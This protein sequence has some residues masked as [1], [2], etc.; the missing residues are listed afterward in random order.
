MKKVLL[1]GSSFNVMPLMKVL[2]NTN[3]EIVV[4]GAYKNDP[5][6]QYSDDSIY[7]DYSIKE[8]LLNVV[9]NNH[10]DA[11]IPTCNDY[12][13]IS[14]SW[15]ASQIGFSGF[16]P[17]EITK[18]IHEKDD[19]RKFCNLNNIKS[20]QMFSDESLIT[21]NNF[22]LIIKPIDSFSGK[23]ISIAQT[24]KELDTAIEKAKRAS[25]T[26]NIIIEEFKQGTLHA[27]TVFIE[28]GNAKL[29]FVTDEFCS[30][31]PY[32]VNSTCMSFLPEDM[33][34]NVFQEIE[35]IIRLLNL[36]S[37][38]MHVQ[39]LVDGH[40]FWIIECTRRAPGDL[41]GKL[42]K[43]TTG[44]DYDELYVNN[45]LGKHGVPKNEYTIQKIMSKHTLTTNLE[46]V[47]ESITFNIPCKNTFIPL[48]NSCDVIKSAPYDRAGIVFSEYTTN[49][50]L[51]KTIP[52]IQNLIEFNYYS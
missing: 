8:E 26:N 20:P 27:I 5:L 45:F 48:K 22:P 17:Y 40:D 41:Y 1:V 31:Y 37:G 28:N 4:C 36:E 43:L 44:I 25:R 21:E 7:A 11:I 34:E 50:E 52:E 29:N 38:L 14:C 30:V 15:V 39:F 32:Q 46:G 2:K 10:F 47:I 18:T 51:K 23:G 24:S 12:S 49:E 3:A 9:Q 35:K 6:H 19:F 13:Y 42:I 33:K 16:E